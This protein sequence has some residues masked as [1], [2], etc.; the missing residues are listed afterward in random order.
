MNALEYLKS[1][2]LIEKD[3]TKFIINKM[4]KIKSE[5]IKNIG[6]VIFI[7]LTLNIYHNIIYYVAYNKGQKDI[8]DE[9]KNK[10]TSEKMAENIFN[11]NER[12]K[13][14]SFFGYR[15]EKNEINN[16]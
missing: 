2:N 13:K 15:I 3:K 4:K 14:V 10:I 11:K 8:F 1:I 5:T 16:K 9:L 12:L 7:I 6:I